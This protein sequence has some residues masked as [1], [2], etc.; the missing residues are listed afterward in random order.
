MITNNTINFLKKLKEN[1]NREWFNENRKLYETTKKEFQDFTDLLISKTIGVDSSIAGLTHKECI[2]RIFKDV[3][4][5]KDKSPYKPNFGTFLASGGRK[6]G[7]AGYYVHIE[8]G[9][10]FIG[11]GIYMPPTE[12]LKKIR[13]LLYGTI[14]EYKSIVSDPDFVK[15]FGEVEGEKL[16]KAP[17]GFSP[18]FPDIEILKFKSYFVHTQISD[19]EILSPDFID[20]AINTFSVMYPLNSYINSHL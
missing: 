1:N 11:G 10:S 4:F 5:S 20:N 16:K 17:R 2:F 19:S 8:P 14:E 13:S 18:D 12:N 15:T 6:S 9:N 3:R 7:K